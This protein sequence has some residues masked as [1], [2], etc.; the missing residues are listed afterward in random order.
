M[1]ETST[2]IVVDT[3]TPVVGSIY[4]TGEFVGTVEPS[5]QV[6]VY[7][8]ASGEVLNTYYNVGDMVEKGAVLLQIN[9]S[10]L[11]NTIAQT[12]ASLSTSAAKAQLNL[13]MAE[14]DLENYYSGVEE[15]YNSALLS[16]E[17]TV[18]SAEK[19]VELASSNLWSQRHTY[20]SAKNGETDT[21]YSDQEL[22]AL[23]DKISQLEIELES[24]QLSLEQAEA[25]LEAVKKQVQEKADSAVD[26]VALAELNADL[27]QQYLALEQLE[28]Q[29]SDY[30]VTAP[31]SGVIEQREIDPYD[32]ASTASAVYVISNKD[33]MTVSFNVSE[34]TLSYMRVGDTVTVDKNGN[35][36]TGYITEVASMVDS[37][38][39]LFTIKATV[40]TSSFELLS[41]STVKIYATTQKVEDEMLVQIDSI[42]YED[43]NPYV[44]VYENG[45]AVQRFVETGISDDSQIQILSGL[46]YSDQVISTWSSHLANGAE[47][48]L[49]GSEE[50]ASGEE[51]G[52]IIGGDIPSE[53]QSGTDSPEGNASEAEAQAPPSSEPEGD[54]A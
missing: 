14:K 12:Q 20:T 3:M 51:S 35:T 25:N 36:C 16:A 2:D 21:D 8:K 15:G 49:V 40:E 31:I 18:E 23:K 47:V 10:T 19:K 11:Q 41:G 9:S 39:G 6:S 30:S 27:T 4:V 45:T 42:Y 48:V 53:D 7:P 46:S 54:A 32:M 52:P 5:Q 26:S 50:E 29:L 13:E 43:G 33:A 38:S 17:A 28:S 24:A 22:Q 44:Y 37:S 34:T 1:E